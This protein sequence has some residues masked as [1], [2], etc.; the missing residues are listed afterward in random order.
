VSTLRF[1]V[2]LTRDEA[3]AVLA[4]MRLRGAASRADHL[5]DCLLAGRAGRADRLTEELGQLGLV[6]NDIAHTAPAD[7]DAAGGDLSRLVSEGAALMRRILRDLNRRGW[8]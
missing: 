3:D 7:G 8:E 1:E 5:R 2:R 4:D 6:L